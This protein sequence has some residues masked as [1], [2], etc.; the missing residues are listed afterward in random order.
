MGGGGE[1]LVRR[2]VATGPGEEAAARRVGKK[3]GEHGGELLGVDGGRDELNRRPG[4]LAQPTE[5]RR[6]GRHPGSKAFADRGGGLAVEG[7]AQL[8]GER[9]RGE[10]GAVALLWQR[11]GEREPVTDPLGRGA[12]G[13]RARARSCET[14]PTKASIA[15]SSCRAP[16]TSAAKASTNS[17]GAFTGSTMPKWATTG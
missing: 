4:Q 15:A 12:I 10:P 8:D 5:V 3:A 6:D 1:R 13:E 2:E 16:R 14:G 9:R 11:S 7:P 17:S